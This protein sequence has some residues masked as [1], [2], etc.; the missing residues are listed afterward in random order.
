MKTIQASKARR[1]WAHLLGHVYH[2][3]DRVIILR[4]GR[5]TA[6]LVHP[7]DVV[8]L[9]RLADEADIDEARRCIADSKGKE[10]LVWPELR[11]W[12]E[13]ER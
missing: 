13:L 10:R 4:N 1:R 5:Q 11:R 7:D 12:A 8:F 3:A 9:E 2:T 6:A